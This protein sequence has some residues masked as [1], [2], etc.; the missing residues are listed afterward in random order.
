MRH[1]FAQFV[2]EQLFQEQRKR[3]ENFQDFR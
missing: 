2:N 1:T 3:E